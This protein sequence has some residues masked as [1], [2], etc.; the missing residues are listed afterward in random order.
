MEFFKEFFMAVDKS[1]FLD[2][3]LEEAKEIDLETDN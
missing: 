3:N 2:D 1:L